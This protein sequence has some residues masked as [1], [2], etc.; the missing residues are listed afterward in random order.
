MHVVFITSEYP[1]PGL[2]H[3]GIGTFVRFLASSLVQYGVEVS[4]VGFYKSNKAASISTEEGVVIH[5]L[6]P[7]RWK[8]MRFFDHSLRLN[9]RLKEINRKQKIDIV[10]AAELG[11]AF[12]QKTS[13]VKYVIRMHGGHHF[14]SQAEKR[15]ISPWRGFQEKR[16][17][18]KADAL[19]GV[20]QYVVNHTASYLGF[21]ATKVP[22][23]FNPVNL[24]KFHQTNPSKIV[25]GRIV[26]VGTVCEKKGVRQLVMAMPAICKEVPTAHLMIAGRDW[27]FSDG[28]S[29]I[30]YLK[31]FIE[32][33]VKDRISFLGTLANTEVPSLIESAELCAYPSH[34]EA[35]PLAWLEGL[36]MGKAVVASKTG[37][38]PEVI[39]DGITGLLCDPYNPIDIAEKINS[40]LKN[41][42]NRDGMGEHA[43]H[44]IMHRFN[45]DKLVRQNIDFYQSVNLL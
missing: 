23:I 44:D 5:R 20:S 22:V 21:D 27:Y 33:D 19:V 26:F 45:I 11:L 9:K 42:E 17:F 28:Q 13:G 30:Q 4:V 41:S 8:S 35:M 10:E 39:E 12:V 29:Y 25:A 34:M 36:A 3:G 14:F 15:K 24:Q 18:A 40:V 7:S 38:G 16:S 2:P 43:R 32:P 6:Q 37:P 1:T 31:K